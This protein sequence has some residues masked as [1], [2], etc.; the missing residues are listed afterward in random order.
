MKNPPGLE[1]PPDTLLDR[2]Y[3]LQSRHLQ[4]L[5]P[6]DPVISDSNKWYSV[7]DV[8]LHSKIFI[9][10]F[11]WENKVMVNRLLVENKVKD[12]WIS[13]WSQCWLIRLCS[14]MRTITAIE[15][16]SDFISCL[17]YDYIHQCSSTLYSGALGTN[18]SRQANHHTR[19]DW[20]P[21]ECLF[22]SQSGSWERWD[23]QNPAREQRMG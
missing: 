21:Q 6:A 10:D 17:G 1:S 4:D 23:R 20:F 22:L 12:L 18:C 16:N 14:K 13:A 3:T 9:L 5:S 2:L 7:C 15:E 11:D 8:Y 19:R